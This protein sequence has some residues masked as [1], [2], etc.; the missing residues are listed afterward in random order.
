MSRVIL[1][2]EAQRVSDLLPLP[3]MILKKSGADS[4]LRFDTL[5]RTSLGLYHQ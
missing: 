3:S 1:N 4:S 5:E 2:P